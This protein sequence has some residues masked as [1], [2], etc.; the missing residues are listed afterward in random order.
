M[1]ADPN[2]GVVIEN[3]TKTQYQG[4]YWNFKG[5]EELIALLKKIK[6]QVKKDRI[7]VG[8]FF[9]DHDSLRK[10]SVP[11]Q[12][13]R[14]VLDGCK[15]QLTEHEYG[16]L[17]KSYQLPGDATK[18]NYVDFNEELEKIFTEKDLEKNPTKKLTEFKAPSILDPKDVLND[19]EEMILHDLLI[20]I[21]IQIAH[22]RLLI[23]PFFQDKDKSNSGFV[24]STRFRSIFDVLKLPLS[25]LQF[26]LISLRFQARAPNEI[27]YVEFDHVLKFYS[28]DHENA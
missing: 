7:R 28:G 24:A 3:K 17:E 2:K 21:G 10:G 22:R 23:K 4:N 9:L 6:V 26:G 25:E 8:E 5:D 14:S 27:N 1:D 12:K 19:E 18:V 15:I 13:F 11:I 20:R 16:V